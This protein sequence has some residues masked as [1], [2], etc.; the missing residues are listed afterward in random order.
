MTTIFA[1][2]KKGVMV[3]DSK[4][5]IG[6]Q[7]IEDPAKVVRVGDELIGF[8]GWATEGD[9]WLAWYKAGQNGPA[10]K[11]TN[12]TALILSREGLRLLDNSGGITV[13]PSGNL[14]V[15]SGGAFARAAFLAGADAKKAV[16]IACKID[17]NSGGTV[18][19]HKLK[20]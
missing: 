12:A 1:D 10:P 20:A 8:A 6:E 11:V 2:A 15:G 13:I 7:W 4:T 19:V 14:G 18:Y 9:R 3:C 17:A 16:E 5:T